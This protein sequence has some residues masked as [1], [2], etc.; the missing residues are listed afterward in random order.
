MNIA[1]A[2]FIWGALLRAY[3]IVLTTNPSKEVCLLDY[4]N[5]DDALAVFNRFMKSYGKD[6]GERPA[7]LVLWLAISE[8]FTCKK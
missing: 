6:F 2:N 8:Q 7:H 4:F 1:P 3:F 5:G